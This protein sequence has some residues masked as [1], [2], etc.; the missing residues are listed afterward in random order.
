MQSRTHS[1][2]L[3]VSRYSRLFQAWPAQKKTGRVAVRSVSAERTISRSHAE[4]GN[5]V[6]GGIVDLGQIDLRNF[7]F[8][9]PGHHAT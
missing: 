7:F 3:Y 8:V 5:E 2:L 4:R 9:D 1:S 6:G